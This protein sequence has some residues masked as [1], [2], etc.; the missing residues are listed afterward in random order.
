MFYFYRANHCSTG[1]I[2]LIGYWGS[3]NKASVNLSEFYLHRNSAKKI[4]KICSIIS[5]SIYI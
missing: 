5:R 3:M 1:A 2:N 4:N